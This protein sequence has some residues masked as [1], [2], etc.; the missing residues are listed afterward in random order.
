M[1]RGGV[2]PRSTVSKGNQE[3]EVLSEAVGV[4]TMWSADGIACG[5][6]S[7][8]GYN[9]NYQWI[10]ESGIARIESAMNQR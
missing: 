8:A 7:S 9:A 4:S 1:W 6:G 5:G 3:K 2:A 10:C